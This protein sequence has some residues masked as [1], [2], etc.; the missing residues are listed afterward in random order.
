MI[1]QIDNIY[2][3]GLIT[4]FVTDFNFYNLQLV[5]FCSDINVVVF[6]TWK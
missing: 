1:N 4:R 6:F 3:I 2:H 5:S